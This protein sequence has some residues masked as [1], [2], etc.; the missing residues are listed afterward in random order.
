MNAPTTSLIDPQSSVASIVLAHSETARLF[1]ELRIDFCC[2][3]EQSLSLA[4]SSRKLPLDDVLTA[5]SDTISARDAAA[6]TEVP[7]HRLS[8]RE[9]V[10]FIVG[11]HHA[12]LR[13]ILP[14]VG[15]LAAKVA[16]VHGDRN[17]RLAGV[18]AHVEALTTALLP[19]LDHEEKTL[20]PAI[21]AAEPDLPLLRAEFVKMKEEH[22]AV[23]ELLGGLRDETESFTLP[24]WACTS[25]RTL[26]SELERLELDTLRHV[27][28]ENHVLVGNL[29]ESR[30]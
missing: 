26:F 12:Y 6:A 9:L 18:K 17:P 20:F 13:E 8:K 27:H 15:A 14:F 5:L 21:L 3:G 29:A 11:T 24:D 16:R 1:Q 28:L 19:H 2:K 4:C 10:E 30:S 25:Y 23:G 22:L 7:A